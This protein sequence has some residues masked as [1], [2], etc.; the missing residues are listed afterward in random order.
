MKALVERNLKVISP[1]QRKDLEQR[2]L[3][4]KQEGIEVNAATFWELESLQSPI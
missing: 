2:V 3:R 4:E 1:G